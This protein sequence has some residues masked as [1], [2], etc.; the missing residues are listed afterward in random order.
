VSD[1][2]SELV[3]RAQGGDGAALTQLV[4]ATQQRVYNLAYRILRNPQEAEDLT[5]EI[6]V[7]VWR[8]LPGFRGDS[9]FTTW[10]HTIATNT[11][12]NRRRKLRR[13][14]ELEMNSDER[15]E[16]I[17]V[18]EGEP[19]PEGRAEMVEQASV[20]STIEQLPPRYALV[21]TMFYQQ[22]LAYSEIAEILNLP[23]GTVKG[24]L[25]RAR[26]ALARRL[27]GV[28]TP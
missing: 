21:L 6:Y 12:L 9:K 17:A 1:P 25:N 4:E 20:W 24:N 8:A 7:R 27:I 11:C 2:L 16:S 10:L 3:S 13:Q 23:L 15:L 18:P 26:N 5:Q 14:I 19:G 22:Q 28:P